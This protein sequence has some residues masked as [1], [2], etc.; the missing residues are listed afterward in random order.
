MTKS[1]TIG[2]TNNIS[3]LVILARSLNLFKSSTYDYKFR[4]FNTAKDNLA[5]INKGWIDFAS[6]ID[7]SIAYLGLE[8]KP[9]VKLIASMQEKYDE[10][11]IAKEHIKT[12]SDLIGKKIAYLPKTSS[13]MYLVKFCEFHNIDINSLNLIEMN[14]EKM[15]GN[16]FAEDID[17]VSLWEPYSSNILITAGKNNQKLTIFNNQDIYKFTVV[18]AAHH[19]VINKNPAV[20]ANFINIIK[21][22]ENYFQTHKKEAINLISKEI[23]QDNKTFENYINKFTLKI[24]E[25]P[26]DFIENVKSYG[27]WIIANDDKYK[28]SKLPRYEKLFDKNHQK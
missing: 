9:K 16:F 17:A 10:V 28:N 23:T 27:N 22:A 13:H 21:T 19:N 5:A 11:I 25:I 12:T 18:L 7:I 3:M 26:D 8:H 6:L 2:I 14:P 24:S 1:Y 20:I 15:V 4:T